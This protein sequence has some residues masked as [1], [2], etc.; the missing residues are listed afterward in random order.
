MNKRQN[1]DNR[2][3]T[4]RRVLP[5]N[6]LAAPTTRS[7]PRK[8]AEPCRE[9]GRN[10]RVLI[11]NSPFW[12]GPRLVRGERRKCAAILSETQSATAQ[13]RQGMCSTGVRPVR[14]CSIG[15]VLEPRGHHANNAHLNSQLPDS[16]LPAARSV[17]RGS[18]DDTQDESVRAFLDSA[19]DGRLL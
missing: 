17:C 4:I 1:P 5:A 2:E 15:S 3:P 14:E 7:V 8:A 16:Q 9:I 10:L 12:G 11:R 6:N 19:G 18:P 13:L